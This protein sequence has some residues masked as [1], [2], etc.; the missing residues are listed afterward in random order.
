MFCLVFD[1]ALLSANVEQVSV[2]R[3]QEF[4]IA[5]F[6]GGALAEMPEVYLIGI[7]AYI[8]ISQESWCLP[9]AGFF[10]IHLW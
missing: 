7:G 1:T 4:F 2:F 3:I 9:C 10:F 8:R 6:R 5:F